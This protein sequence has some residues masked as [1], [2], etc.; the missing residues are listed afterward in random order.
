MRDPNRIHPTLERLQRVW[1]LH[2]DL[3]L[4]QILLNAFTEPAT[5]YYVEDD[6]LIERIEH[7]ADIKSGSFGTWARK[8]G[9]A[10]DKPQ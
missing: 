7:R 6:E 4:G 5:L 10:M 9:D 2:P 8:Y 1:L 3:R